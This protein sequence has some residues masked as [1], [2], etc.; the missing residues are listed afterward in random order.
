MFIVLFAAALIFGLALTLAPA[1]QTR[2]AA[3]LPQADGGQTIY[4]TRCAVCHGIEGDGIGPGAEFLDPRPRDF[5]RGWYKIRTTTSGQLATDADLFKVIANGMPGTTMPA[6]GDV[7][8]EDEIRAVA[9]YIKTFSRRYEREEPIAAPLG[10]S[11]ESSAES[12]AR[13]KELFDGA[14]AECAKCHGSAGR[15][16]G[17]S[18]NDL[19]EDA[20]GDVIVP[21]DLTMPWLFR[22]GGTV[23]DIF[24]RLN[25]G[26]TGSP[27][28]S[29]AEVLTSDDLW[30]LSNYIDSLAT[31]ASP[32]LQVAIT[33]A[34]NLG[35]IPDDPE[36]P[37]WQT[38]TEF[39]FPLLGQI[40]RE[41]RNYTPSIKGVWVR[42]LYN[43]SELALL[44]KWH[45]RF[46]DAGG[47]E[48]A[49]GI[50]GTS[51]GFAVQFPAELPDGDKRPYF[52]FGDSSNAV[53]LWY[54]SAAEDGVEER[55]G[56]GADAIAAQSTQNVQG[57]ASFAAGEYTLVVRRALNTNDAE[58]IQFEAGK[59]IP[60]SFI[61]WDGWRGEQ[62]TSGAISSW[63]MVYLE[64]PVAVIN[65]VWIP[66][67]VLIVVL[68]EGLI[69]WQVRRSNRDE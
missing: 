69:V 60:L 41:P 28:P 51:D 47:A 23:D 64:E 52:V 44:I 39:Y 16:D 29:Y 57:A 66:V 4:E 65:Y 24:L 43:D 27:M 13:G 36:A 45:D 2:A 18:A 31:E 37:E 62:D 32:E 33:A 20:F 61:A 3:P 14:E 12:I 25:T 46:E 55:T 35:P 22:G 68:L 1:S 40:I 11:V 26:L 54:W 53:N 50:E 42:A 10:A 7:L 48:G 19:T 63:Y 38:A 8:S 58:D 56:R 6:W 21:A 5:R 9:S 49:G 67:V 17:P 34:Q 30:H 15:G 59:F